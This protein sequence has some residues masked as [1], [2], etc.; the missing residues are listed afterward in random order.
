MRLHKFLAQMGINSRRNCEKLI[1]KGKVKVNN[2]IITQLGTEIDT[3]KDKIK[4]NN[5][6]VH[7]KVPRI[8][9][10]LN[11]P[12]GF[13][14]TYHDPFGRPTIYDLLKK[15]KIK[16]NYAGRLD[17]DSEGL[18]FLTNDGELINQITHPKKKIKKVYLVKIKGFPNDNDLRVLT[19]GVPI[20]HIFTTNPCQLK[21]LKKNKNN[22]IV[23]ISI[24]EG[25]KRQ[26][27]RMFSYL[28]FQ[29]LKLTRTQIGILNLK[30]LKSGQ[31]R[32]LGKQ[33]II[34]YKQFLENN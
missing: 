17:L 10:L 4:V 3:N 16:L 33:E 22:C 25:K 6:I 11:K 18:V 8:Y 15:I 1:V 2:V 14:C 24:N 29:V 27:R 19:N 20:S 34:N 31:Y 21:I 5:K 7:K 28:G 23:E 26:I 9:V 32:F 12:R 13:L 30:G